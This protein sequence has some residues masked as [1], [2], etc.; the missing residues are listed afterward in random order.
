VL[1]GLFLARGPIFRLFRR[2]PDRMK[3]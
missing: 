3:R 1:T 2:K